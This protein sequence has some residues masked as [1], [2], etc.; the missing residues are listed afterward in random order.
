M[1]EKIKT[2]IFKLGRKFEVVNG[3]SKELWHIT[4]PENDSGRVTEGFWQKFIENL[5]DCFPY[6]LNWDL[7]PNQPVYEYKCSEVSLKKEIKRYGGYS[8]SKRHSYA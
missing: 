8:R 1:G 3:E 7:Y 2:F 4:S 6:R 5:K